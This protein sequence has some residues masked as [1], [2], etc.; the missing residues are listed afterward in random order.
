MGSKILQGL[1]IKSTEKKMLLWSIALACLVE[2]ARCY[3]AV[4]P[5]TLFLNHFG[6]ANLPQIY[7]VNAVLYLMIGS[8]YDFFASRFSFN[9]LIMGL[10]LLIGGITIC[11]GSLL[12]GV[13]GAWIIVLLILWS[14][15][16]KSLL[17]FGLWS[18]FNQIYNLQQGKRLF[19]MIHSSQSISG[20]FAGFLLPAL[21]LVITTDQVV[22]LVGILI[23]F[24]AGILVKLLQIKREEVDDKETPDAGVEANQ[25]VV[26][27]WHDGYILKLM[28][29]VILGV[30]TQSFINVLFNSLAEE[31]YPGKAALSG[32]LS[33]FN[34]LGY[35]VELLLNL[36]A[37]RRI[38][39][40]FGLIASVMLHPMLLV[41]ISIIILIISSAIPSSFVS[42]FWFVTLL[43]LVETSF[44][45]TIAS[46]SNLLLLQPLQPHLRRLVLSKNNMLITPI[47]VVL[48]CMILM[49]VTNTVGVVVLW[50]ILAVL[51]FC[52]LSI[53]TSWVLK[54]DY[55]KVLTKAIHQRYT[56]ASELHPPGKESLYLF[57]Q[58]LL[59][60]YPDEVLYALSAME[61]IDSALFVKEL[62]LVFKSPEP[63]VRQ[64]VLQ[65]I[66]QYHITAFYDDILL[67]LDVEPNPAL[68]AQAIATVAELNYD[69]A[70]ANI[71]QLVND[72]SSLICRAALIAMMRYGDGLVQ[73]DTL[74]KISHMLCS[75]Q[76]SSRLSAVFIIGEINNKHTNAMLA[77]LLS[78]P[79]K[80]IRQEVLRSIIKTG[81][82]VCFDEVLK[83]IHFLRLSGTILKRFLALTPAIMPI[84]QANFLNYPHIAKFK[85][86]YVMGKM[87]L[88]T[89]TEFLENTALTSQG[90]LRQVALRSLK[91]MRSPASVIFCEKSHQK[92]KE[93]VVYLKEQYSCLQ[94]IPMIELTQLLRDTVRR[95]I[96]LSVERLLLYV[97]IGYHNKSIIEI[98][99]KLEIGSTNEAGY[100]LELLDEILSTE[101][102]AIISPILTSIY[103]LEG[104]SNSELDSAHFQACI[105]TQLQEE[106]NEYL[107][108]L[109]CIACLYIIKTI[110]KDSFAFEIERLKQSKSAI[111]QET[112]I[113]LES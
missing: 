110:G 19:G 109:S 75:D 33:I 42:I 61:Q 34:G 59:S 6:G 96:A 108:L 83:R 105:K 71:A 81:H 77:N 49:V 57:R 54:S 103:L 56:I 4:A 30:F 16:A 87:P 38:V 13:S 45:S 44:R 85:L 29:I 47:A 37:Y 111:I 20:L 7:L 63:G 14:I 1:Q 98:K 88:A 3:L 5:M 39:G 50:F 64:L 23:F 95:K 17:D 68:K 2:V 67:M 72:P 26:H 35:G 86:L 15:I 102:K 46:T 74:K 55:I 25:S 107:T 82:E 80:R 91:D 8:V 73:Q 69:K 112:L 31:H 60:P 18:V 52:T 11:L 106:G 21:L 93:E 78:D 84:I 104:V 12:I 10:M 28:V 97:A 113:W 76:V 89:A 92:I 53:M 43:S 66:G 94:M 99:I 41:L 70:R 51:I 90:D 48:V 79:S 101:D 9:R 24:A 58:A 27:L 100:A 32:F 22:I 65:K 62:N 36:F 40:R